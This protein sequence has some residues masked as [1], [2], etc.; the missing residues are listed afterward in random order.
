[1]RVKLLPISAL[2]LATCASAQTR[3]LYPFFDENHKWGYLDKRGEVAIPAQFDFASVFHD[4]LAQVRK[5]GS[6]GFIDT[7]G[8]TAID[9]GRRGAT[10]FSEDRAAVRAPGTEGRYGFIDTHG[11][12]TVPHEYIIAR[13]YS[14]GVAS[15][16]TGTS[17]IR[18]A[19][20]RKCFYIDLN[21]AKA[22]E[23]EFEGAG[24]FHEGRAWVY[25]GKKYGFI[26]HRGVLVIEPRFMSR[27][28]FSEGL[29]AVEVKCPDRKGNCMGYIDKMGNM[30]IPARFRAGRPFSEGLA[31]VRE[32]A[33][34]GYIDKS[35]EY[36]IPSSFLGAQR[37]SLGLAAVQTAE[38]KWGYI[39]H[40]G[41]LGIPARF[42]NVGD[43][44]GDGL[45][46][47]ALK[48]KPPSSGGGIVGRSHG[49]ALWSGYVDR[50]GKIV[51]KAPGEY[52]E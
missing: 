13:E 31:A 24:S 40:S 12:A 30:A 18:T 29:A 41:A 11:R 25:V 15:V 6:G 4:G 43:F 37:F 23:A 20:N 36:A 45:A 39:D 38:K 17:M 49:G 33:Q 10:D 9:L 42:E 16:C 7:A 14:E 1:M 52:V 2:L 46:G 34:F 22:F 32:S 50:S 48:P 35:G 8:K 28:D 21:G 47:I 26:D 44:F 51:W 27:S 3:Q 19:V 5:G